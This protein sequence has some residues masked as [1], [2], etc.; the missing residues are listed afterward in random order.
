MILFLLILAPFIGIFAGVGVV[1][2]GSI[3]AHKAA[4]IAAQEAQAARDMELFIE[5]Q[6]KAAEAEKRRIQAARIDSEL[7]HYEQV[8]YDLETLGR[9]KMTLRQR[10]ALDEKTFRIDKKITEL[11]EKLEMIGD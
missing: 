5:A 8:L 2:H 4:K 7:A 3:S 9:E 11:R 6:Q 1:I 10:I